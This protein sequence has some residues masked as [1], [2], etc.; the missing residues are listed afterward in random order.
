[1]LSGNPHDQLAIAYHLIV[2]NKRIED[3]AAK[4]DL[5]DLY[6]TSSPPPFYE[7][8][9]KQPFSTKQRALSGNSSTLERQRT[10]N[11]NNDKNKTT[12]MKKAKWHLGKMN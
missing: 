4:L 3:E 11:G 2:D 7:N 1:M 9:S 12:P 5:K 8:F 10:I 6:I